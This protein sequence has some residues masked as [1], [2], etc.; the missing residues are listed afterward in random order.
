MN[1][2]EKVQFFLNR[3]PYDGIP[4][5][6]DPNT[7][8]LIVLR[9]VL[10]A[11]PRA[12]VVTPDAELAGRLSGELALLVEQLKLPFQAGLL[13]EQL[14]GRLYSPAVDLE[15]SAI[16]HQ[17]LHGDFRLLVASVQAVLAPVVKPAVL[18]E[19]EFVLHPGMYIKFNDLLERLLK[20]DYDDEYEVNTTAEFARRGG[21]IDLYS[22]AHE[23][24][25][26]LEFWGDQLESIRQFSPKTQR[27][28][29]LVSEYQIIGRG[30]M[31]N[32][33]GEPG[34][35]FDYLRC[36]EADLLLAFP[37]E[38]RRHLAQFGSAD[39]AEL[40]ERELAGLPAEKKFLLSD[41]AESAELP[42]VS[43]ECYPAVAHL[44]KLLP[45]ETLP[46]G[47]ELLRQQIAGQIRQ[48]LDC[49]Y[50]VALLAPDDS[51]L[52]HI[53]NWC[54]VYG[55]PV[56]AVEI[57]VGRLPG[58]W[59]LPADELVLLT[60]RELFASNFLNHKGGVPVPLR[61]LQNND[62]EDAVIAEL[63]EGDYAVHL[64]HGIGIF[65]GIREIDTR[66][67]VREVMVLEYAD[68]AILYVP[69]YQAGQVSRYV[70]AAGKV[71]LHRLGGRKWTQDK[72]GTLRAVR[73]YAADLLRLQAVRSASEGLPLPPEGLEQQIFENSF[74]FQETPD[75]LRAISEIKHDLAG[76]H[77]MDRLLCGD[78]GYGKTEVAMRAAFRM[79]QAGYQVAILAPTTVLAQQHYYSFTAR[80]AE[81]PFNI[82]M[83]SRFRSNR[84][85]LEIVRK[86][87]DGRI[88]IVIGT[89]RLCQ[90]DVK[91]KNLGLIIVDEEQRFGVAHKEHIRQQ[92]AALHVLTMSA[93][94]IPR[95]LYLAMA[96]ARDLSTIMT[97]PV[98]RLPI[99]TIIS[100]HDEAV[101]VEAIRNEL[102]RKGQVYYLHNRVYSINN[103][104]EKLRRLMPEVRF[105]VAHGQMEEGELE[106]IMAD[107]LA[108]VIDVL[109]ST[110][111]IE[112]GLDV[113]N[114]NTIII[115]RAD[116][117]GLAELYQLRGRVGRWSN[118][119]YAYL[120]LPPQEAITSD[121]RKRIAAIRR[122]THLGAG[123]Q[124]ALRD[125]EIRGAG[126]ILGAEQSG[127]I[128]AVGFEL[129]CQLLRNEVAAL[130]GE[131]VEFLPDV[132]LAIDFIR[133][134]HR[135]PERYL[136]VGISPEFIPSERLR[137][138]VYRKLSVLSGE[139]QLEAFSEELSDRF[140]RLPR[141]V[142]DLLTVTRIRILAARA[143]FV[144]VNVVDGKVTLQNAQGSVYRHNNLLP[145]I[146]PALPPAAQLLK[147]LD[148]LQRI[149]WHG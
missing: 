24:P 111:I 9:T 46:G 80:F 144:L 27:T 141:E 143:G 146:N 110:T 113:P 1:W 79:V 43:A 130:K 94:P 88:D 74:S 84:E 127:H 122:Y 102:A 6:V 73:D 38:C 124:L 147:L 90:N 137:V 25:V 36:A 97:A 149:V 40:L 131:K 125:L 133:F 81:Y 39:A 89:H 148:I 140:G 104:A 132:E 54:E 77:P 120:L 4:G 30:Q 7:L 71:A 93:T 67:V 82:D 135:A 32:R 136:A 14:A 119:A 106:L 19:S 65:R 76:D 95:T 121:G 12:L 55:I 64:S 33:F 13:P 37:E 51:G 15:R 26:R 60:E 109:I 57:A 63:D 123:F 53:R 92:R 48:Y 128:N 50:Q 35:F 98:A 129:Y 87:A 138:D 41:A 52:Q 47:M 8:S 31:D 18:Q 17:V 44:T 70:G 58:G 116:R 126:N 59:L 99:K 96:G 103:V 16:L 56:A 145:V 62:A 139:E 101:I 78:V 21:I 86:L 28:T 83:L 23:F 22:P 112:S 117:F 49:N 5:G 69:L 61:P 72:Q 75:Q 34:T 105:A 11:G 134:A 107:F 10:N 45:E 29:G 68:N 91:F 66:G 108:G 142:K 118:Q 115:E 2:Q 3:G 42:T 85:Q 100:Q 20:L 114:A